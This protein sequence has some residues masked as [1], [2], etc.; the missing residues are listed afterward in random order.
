M[1]IRDLISPFTAWKYAFRDPVTIRDPLNDRLVKRLYQILYETSTVQAR[2]LLE[3][4]RDSLQAHGFS[5]SEIKGI[6]DGIIEPPRSYN[7]EAVG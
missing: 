7:R 5:D 4:Y 3:S 1:G 2:Q 6:I